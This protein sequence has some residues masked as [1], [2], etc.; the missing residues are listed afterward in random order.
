MIVTVFARIL[1]KLFAPK[2]KTAD[3]VDA[4]FEAGAAGYRAEHGVV[5]NWRKSIVD[6]LKA[7]GIA[8][9]FDDRRDLWAEFGLDGEY[10]GSAEQNL[11]LIDVLR[12]QVAFGDFAR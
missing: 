2:K 6:A 10:T 1:Y 7:I 9:S 4:R 8:D 3:E 11:K 5:L 12:E